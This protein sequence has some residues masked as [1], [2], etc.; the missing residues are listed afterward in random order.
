MSVAVL[1]FFIE[2]RAVFL[3]EQGNGWY[4]VGPY[5]AAQAT[6]ALPGIFLIALIS[7]VLMASS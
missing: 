4:G 3:R 5:V 2:D 6:T 1:P 7:S